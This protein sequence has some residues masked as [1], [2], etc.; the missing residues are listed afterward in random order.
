MQYCLIVPHT[1]NI[2]FPH[3]WEITA[4]GGEAG[5]HIM[6]RRPPSTLERERLPV[7]EE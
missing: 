7:M 5:T 1:H 3:R 4:K 2:H 6:L